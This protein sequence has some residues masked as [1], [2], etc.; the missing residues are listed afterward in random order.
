MGGE[1]QPTLRKTALMTSLTTER[2]SVNTKQIFAETIAQVQGAMVKRLEQEVERKL[3]ESITAMLQRESYGR[4]AEVPTWVEIEGTC[5]RCG[6]RK[7]HRFSRNGGRTRNLLTLWGWLVIWVQRLLCECGGSVRLEYEEWLRP[8]QRIG[9]D[10]DKQVQRWGGL[11]LSLRQMQQELD[12]LF[13][14]PLALRTL[15]RR[16][17]QLQASTSATTEM[18]VPPILQIDAIWVTQLTPTGTFHRDRKGRLRPDKSRRK[19]PLFIALGVWPDTERVEILAWH[20]GDS[21]DEAGWVLFLEQLEALGVRGEN[22]LELIIHDGGSG[23]CAALRTVF[24]DAEQQRCLFHKLRNIYNAIRIQDEQ[25]SRQQRRRLKKRIF[26]DF[27]AIYQ[28]KRWDTMLRRY[29]KVC[30]QYRLT[31]PDAVQTL[32]RDFRQTITYFFIQRSHP[33]WQLRHLRTTSRLE[34]F[35]RCIRRRARA[36]STYHSDAGVSAMMNQE[37]LAFNTAHA[38]I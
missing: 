8:Y 12:H 26:K 7:S 4:R 32:R 1:N 10:V 21:E 9:E 31:Q 11:C 28:A 15:N 6:S 30:R 2:R 14:G 38:Q 19:R 5:Q 18:P 33:D 29:L 24:F 16:L 25:L 20:L 36:A 23:L 35:N 34:R 3:Q 17:H 27:H 22:G 37:V 13:I